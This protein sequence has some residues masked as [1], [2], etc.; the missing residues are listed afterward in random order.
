MIDQKQLRIVIV[1]GVAGGASAAARAR[2][3]A[4]NASIV[5]FERGPHAS[6]ANCG[7]PYYLGG[8]I[9]HRERLL[10]AGP[11]QLQR[12]LD[13]D[14]RTRSEVIAID[15]KSRTVRVRELDGGREY[16][17]PYDY[18]ILAPGAAPI[19]PPALL[20]K[21]GQD[22]PRIHSLRNLPDIDRIKKVVDAGVKSA[23]VVGGGFIGLEVAEQLVRRH[24]KTTLVEALPQVMP[25]LDAEMVTP[26]HETLV[27]HGVDLRLGKG[28]VGIEPLKNER[29]RVLLEGGDAVDTDLVVLAIGV[30]PESALAKQAGL[31]TGARGAIRVDGHLRTSDSRIYAVG[32]AIETTDPVLG[33]S[34]QVPLAGPANRQG[35]LAADHLLASAGVT[36]AGPDALV[37]PGSLGTSI[38]RVFDLAVGM[39]GASEKALRKVGKTLHV[40]YEVVQVHPFHHAS[41]DPGAERLGL[42]LLFE[43]PTGRV[44][45]VQVVGKQGVDKRI[46]VLAMALRMKASVFDLE[47]AEL[48]Y[49]PPFGSAKDPVNLAAF[50]ATNILRAI[51]EPITVPELDDS[52]ATNSDAVTVLDVRTEAE[53]DADAVPDSLSI[54]LEQLRDRMDEVPVDRPVVTYCA[55]G[56]RGYLAERILR[57]R[58]VPNVRNLVGGFATWRH[59]HPRQTVRES[60]L[61]PDRA[62]SH[63]TNGS[64]S[65]VTPGDRIDG[66]DANVL[67]V[68]GMQCPGPLLGVAEKMRN[69]PAGSELRVLADDP[70]FCTD[71]DSWSRKKG[72]AL[73]TTDRE[74]DHYVL[75]LRAGKEEID[76]TASQAQA[77]TA[78]PRVG[79]DQT[80]LVLSDD[81]DRALASFILANAGAAMGNKVTL[82]FTFWG[83][84]VLRKEHPPRVAKGLLDR[85]FGWMM[86]RGAGKLK[87]SKMNMGGMGTAMMKQVMKSKGVASLDELIAESLRQGVRLVACTMSMDVMGLK[88]EELIDGVELGGAGAYLGEADG[89]RVNLVF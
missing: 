52:I 65:Q 19:R 15:R 20:E 7:L 68:R 72:H 9:E 89:A 51:T 75:A 38:A 26:I 41:Y 4:E 37:Y 17:E 76:K 74:A 47:Q 5:V 30:R 3:L 13:L 22:H 66:A 61:R 25:P 36:G 27:R 88:Q 64:G 70:G 48:A 87:L 42:K 59:F 55:V 56:Q 63:A 21:V 33:G 79:A 10:V 28:V 35:R 12:W 23:L 60:G 85:M 84:N 24:V 78:E 69:A 67:D 81:L 2:R 77:T 45:G 73:R 53:H 44:L 31:E 50:Q 49:A 54:P 86:P 29:V 16:D 11:T 62:V 83:L 58:G 8:E 80:L 71:L 1:G 46:D 82:F 40:D 34:A 57:Q 6:F 18:L 14:V 39:T 43:R 32:D